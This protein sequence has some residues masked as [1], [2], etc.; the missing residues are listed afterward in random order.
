LRLSRLPVTDA[1]TR[2][3]LL[4]L[5]GV[6]SP[7]L[8][9]VSPREPLQA[10]PLASLP[11]A[12]RGLVKGNFKQGFRWNDLDGENYL[13]LT[14]TGAFEP[15]GRKARPNNPTNGQD[16]ELYA[17]RFVNVNGQ[18]LQ[19]W[20]VTDFVR[21]CPLDVTAEF[22][23]AATEITDLDNDGF[24]EVWMMYKTACRGDVS[25]A[26]LKIIMYEGTQKYAMR[27]TTHITQSG[28]VAGGDRTPDA[29]LR[30]NRT[31]LRHAERKWKQFYVEFPSS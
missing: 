15:S 29:R 17:Y 6:V 23:S 4:I 28:I 3:L 22:L 11:A 27:G 12:A 19:V 10:F 26:V 31:F 21:D 30:A 2:W 20:R 24:A 25:P 7:V 9:R 13:I 14:E 1:V 8:A 5:V 16:A 18:F